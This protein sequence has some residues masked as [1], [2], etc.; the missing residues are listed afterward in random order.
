MAACRPSLCQAEPRAAL[1]QDWSRAI[2]Y[3]RLWL[4]LPGLW[5]SLFATQAPPMLPR[6]RS[7]EP[8]DSRGPPPRDL[9]PINQGRRG[10]DDDPPAKRARGGAAAAAPP[11]KEANPRFRE[12]KEDEEDED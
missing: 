8:R 11:P 12:D 2:A 3:R 5:D 10:R 4:R 7:F 9:S 6:R 1:R